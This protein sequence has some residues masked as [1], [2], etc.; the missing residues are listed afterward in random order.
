MAYDKDSISQ[1]KKKGMFGDNF[2]PMALGLSND[3]KKR[4]VKELAA[5]SGEMKGANTEAPGAAQNGTDAE[6]FKPAVKK[7]KKSPGFFAFLWRFLN[8]IFT[9]TRPSDYDKQQAVKA[10]R[11]AVK[12]I[13]PP[14]MTFAPDL[15]TGELGR[16]IH[17]L[18]QYLAPLGPLFDDMI[19]N[20]DAEGRF[21]FQL[22]Y[23][24]TTLATLDRGY[25]FLFT[26]DGLRKHISG[27]RDDMARVRVKEMIESFL[28][29]VS[30]EERRYVNRHFGDVL[31]CYDLIRFNFAGFLRFF[32]PSY[33]VE[34]QN[35]EFHDIRPDEV[36]NDLKIL[37]G[38]II[39]VPLEQMR[40][41]V[42]LIGN[43]FKLRLRERMDEEYADKIEEHLM[44][45]GMKNY[46]SMGAALMKPVSGGQITLLVRYV[47]QNRTYEPRA[48]RRISN[49][50]DEYTRNFRR[51]MDIRLERI[52]TRRR[53]EEVSSK[54]QE[55]F[56]TS[57]PLRGYFYNDDT[58]SIL[59]RMDLSPFVYTTAYYVCMRFYSEKFPEHVKRSLNR[60]IVEGSY[61]DS[62]VRRV[63]SEEFYR[64]EEL[65]ERLIQ[66]SEFVSL[67]KER[68]ILLHGMIQKFKGNVV[69]KKT[70]NARIATV[71]EGLHPILLDIRESVNNLQG[72]LARIEADINAINPKAIDNLSK[73]GAHI[74]TRFLQDL[75]RSARDYTLFSGLMAE[76]FRDI[77][78]T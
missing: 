57:E 47:T 37:E 21:N 64:S 36:L 72:V 76:T 18:H 54:L 49:F 1:A 66:F 27:D 69:A 19:D 17:L 55:L 26:E 53:Q 56:S 67:H 34:S 33:A 73:I 15:V 13:K 77:R 60:L 11:D 50:F 41:A 39:S 44:R 65:C 6:H 46:A 62:L 40:I 75:R 52:L 22:Y 9:G 8:M 5:V 78:D 74:N 29:S 68:G 12:R 38:L 4:I 63:M 48:Q 32:C 10:L 61:K 58:N 3:E 59:Y 71:N 51:V 16:Q 25:E 20:S 31:N 14:I 7:R 2:D 43:Y 42:S 24:M 28:N 35:N 23:L 45:I 30:E 70:L